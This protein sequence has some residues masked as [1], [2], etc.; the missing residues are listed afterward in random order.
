MRHPTGSERLRLLCFPHSAAGPLVY[1]PWR[2]L[3]G[4]EV[5]VCAV[6][7]PGRGRRLREP[8]ARRWEPLVDEAAAALTALPPLPYAVHGHSLGALLAY[9][10]CRALARLPVPQPSALVVSGMAAPSLWPVRDPVHHLPDDELLARV[11]DFVTLPAGALADDDV[12]AQLL[13]LLRADLEVS[14]TYRHQPGPPLTCPV[15]VLAGSDDPFTPAER[16]VRVWAAH[17]SGPCRSRTFAGGHHFLH[18]NPEAPAEVRTLL[19]T[20]QLPEAT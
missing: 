11:G 17:T 1:R 8:A 5:D 2:R 20:L 19:G 4:A 16:H 9:E 7:Y 13:P 18:E 6:E 14:E 12:R 3:L 10:T 15:T